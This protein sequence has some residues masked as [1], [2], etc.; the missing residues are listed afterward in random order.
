MTEATTNET[1]VETTETDDVLFTV[2]T[3]LDASETEI[4]SPY[5]I[6]K[7]LNAMRKALG[8]EKELPP[9]MLYQYASKGMINGTKLSKRFARDEVQA[10]SIK[11]LKKALNK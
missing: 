8:F 9:Q 10:F 4:Y 3:V 2:T 6:A 1:T 7:V 5:A 11:Y